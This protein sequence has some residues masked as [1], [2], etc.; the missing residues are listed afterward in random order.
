MVH[1]TAG[2]RPL[3]LLLGGTSETADLAAVMRE[4][5]WPVLV[6][7]ATDAPLDLPQGVE[8]RCGR[9][10]AAGLAA[11]CRSRHVQVLVDASHPYATTLHAE[12]ESAAVQVGIPH[13]RF[14]RDTSELPLDARIVSDHEAAAR[15]AFACGGPVVLTTGSRHLEP[16]VREARRTGL[17]LIARVL[18]HPDGLA[19]CQQAG[20]SPAEI[21]TGRGPFS[22]E[23]N[24]D[25][26][27]H[28]EAACLVTK[29]SGEAGGL[30]AKVE[31]A[32][33]HGA[34]LVIVQRPE[35]Q[36]LA[37]AALLQTLS[38]LMELPHASL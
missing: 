27:R 24:L 21:I 23:A 28:A 31:A 20:L 17:P 25:L 35:D 38:T 5:G 4:C 3:I 12:A 29:D 14:M 7:T 9:L 11:L 32:R 36:G 10:D 15:A 19:A 6:S 22:L 1:H 13:L 16:Y 18:D 8:R 2:V 37:R 34:A 26:L 33:R 30:T